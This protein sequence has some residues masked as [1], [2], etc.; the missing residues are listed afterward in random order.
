MIRTEF[1]KHADVRDPAVIE[2][3]KSNAVRGLANYL[4]IESISKD[5]KLKE[6]ADAFNKKELDSVSPSDNGSPYP[7]SGKD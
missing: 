6:H 7:Q 1:R 5:K 3:L 4:M 2:Q